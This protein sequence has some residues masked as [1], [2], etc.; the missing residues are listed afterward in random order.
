MQHA[1]TQISLRIR[2]VW[3]ESSQGTMLVAKELK[4][5]QAD[6]EVS[7]QTARLRRLIWVFAWRTCNLVGND[8][9]RLNCILLT[10]HLYLNCDH[11]NNNRCQTSSSIYSKYLDIS[12]PYHAKGKTF[13]HQ[14]NYVYSCNC[15]ICSDLC[16]TQE[17][18]KHTKKK[19]KMKKKT[20]VYHTCPF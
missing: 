7:D 9:P 14:H 8:V 10:F 3:S 12:T 19:C 17:G 15:N 11:S 2:V 1:N 6:N 5:L 16:Q 18:W 4:G 20:F 13:R